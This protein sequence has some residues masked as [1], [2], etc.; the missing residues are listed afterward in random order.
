MSER[1]GTYL[2]PCSSYST[3]VGTDRRKAHFRSSLLE[4]GTT[5]SD[6]PRRP[7]SMSSRRSPLSA[8]WG[9]V[10]IAGGMVGVKG[11]VDELHVGQV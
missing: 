3:M 8:R 4:P 9:R 11:V 10:W 5:R 2:R 1:V 6:V 7:A